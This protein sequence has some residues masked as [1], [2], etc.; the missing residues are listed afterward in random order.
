MLCNLGMSSCQI[1]ISNQYSSIAAVRTP[2]PL[3]SIGNFRI[4]LMSFF[5]HPPN[6]STWPTCNIPWRQVAI[7][8]RVPFLCQLRVLLCQ[9]IL[10]QIQVLLL[11]NLTVLCCLTYAGRRPSMTFSRSAA[12]RRQK[13]DVGSR[14][15]LFDIQ[16]NP[17]FENPCLI[18]RPRSE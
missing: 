7:Q 18:K 6:F 16:D 9:T 15:F 14:P 2:A 11:L 3:A 13:S 4:P 10:L 1:I 5:T 12:V 8:R 17:F